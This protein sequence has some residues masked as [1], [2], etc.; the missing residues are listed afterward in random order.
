MKTADF[1]RQQVR[2]ARELLEATVEGVTP[3]Q[4]TWRPTGKGAP[5]A[6]QYAHVVASQDAA[7]HSLLLG[8]RPLL[9]ATEWAT[10]SGMSELPPPLGHSWERWSRDAT[11]DLPELRAYAASVYE[12]SDAAFA[13][14]GDDDLQRPIDLSAAGF[15]EATM[16]FMLL[17]GWVNNVFLHC[18]EI[19]C[20]KGMQGEQG[21]PV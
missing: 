5:I 12:A 17:N 6:V 8:G 9:A 19:A 21:Y 11:F 15:G 2:E 4:A 1:F 20:L 16:A 7:L 10:G 3:A 13:S 18:G 14:L